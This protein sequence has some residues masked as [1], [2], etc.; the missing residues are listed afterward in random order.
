MVQHQGAGIAILG[1]DLHLGVQPLQHLG[2]IAGV[3]V[4]GDSLG[5]GLGV[6]PHLILAHHVQ[7]VVVPPVAVKVLGG[8]EAGIVRKGELVHLVDAQLIQRAVGVFLHRYRVVLLG[9]RQR[10]ERAHTQQGG[11]CAQQHGD[12][13]FHDISSSLF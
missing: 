6:H 5:V 3:A 11:Q 10:R 2:Q 13:F 7:Q 12:L 8:N 1:G 4:H 9:C